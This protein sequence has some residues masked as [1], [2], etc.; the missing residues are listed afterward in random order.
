M[1]QAK[2]LPT[3]R[4]LGEPPG[5]RQAGES[6]TAGIDVHL[7]D[8]QIVRRWKRAACPLAAS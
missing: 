1:V 4:R 3:E 6:A 2:P 8:F 7:T 5:T